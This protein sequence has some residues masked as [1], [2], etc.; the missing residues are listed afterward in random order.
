MMRYRL[1]TLL[2]V[3]ALGPLIIG[4]TCPPVFRAVSD[5]L[6][7]DE[8]AQA[9]FDRI[10]EQLL[11]DTAI[12]SSLTKALSPTEDLSMTSGHSRPI[13][14]RPFRS[15]MK[16]SCCFP[17][18]TST[19]ARLASP[20]PKSTSM[21]RLSIRD[22]LWLT[23][24]VAEGGKGVRP[25]Y[26]RFPRALPCVDAATKAGHVR[27]GLRLAYQCCQWLGR[28]RPNLRPRAEIGRDGTLHFFRRRPNSTLVS[29]VHDFDV[30]Q[31]E[32]VGDV[33]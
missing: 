25:N 10:L 12:R 9:E 11:T 28:D 15:L 16:S 8:I 14:C 7:R 30:A 32:G 24:V 20:P 27:L 4:W 1:R 17:P 6:R 21:F 2:I 5:W 22:V 31:N 33:G 29:A 19:L 18:I 13:V 23:V 26:D 3:L